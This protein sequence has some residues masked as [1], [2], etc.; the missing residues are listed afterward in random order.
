MEYARRIMHVYC[1]MKSGMGVPSLPCHSTIGIRGCVTYGVFPAPSDSSP[2]PRPPHQLTASRSSHYSSTPLLLLLF[3]LKAF[4]RGKSVKGTDRFINQQH[5]TAQQFIL[6]PCII[7]PFIYR[8]KGSLAYHFGRGPTGRH[9]PFN[10]QTA[11]RTH[12]LEFL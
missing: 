10:R 3:R 7:L 6:K 12:I 5:P 1:S 2:R 4:H 11:I 8:F 9:V